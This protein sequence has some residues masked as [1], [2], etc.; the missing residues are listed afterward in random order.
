M[1]KLLNLIGDWNP[2]LFR[3]LKGRFTRRNMAIAIGASLAT[4]LL[5]VLSYLGS[6]PD[7]IESKYRYSR[8][9]TGNLDTYS[10]IRE[11][12]RS[13][14]VGDWFVNWQLWNFDLFMA[15]SIT[16]IGILL[17]I[18]SHLINADLTKEEHRGTLGFVRLSPQPAQKIILGKILGVP[19]LV[20]LGIALALPLHF[21]VGLQAHIAAPWIAM[22][23]FMAIAACFTCFSVAVLW[24]F[25]GQ[26]FFGGF[27]TWLY[28]GSLGFYLMIM[29]ILCFE[30]NLPSDSPFDWLRVV[31]P[32]NIFYYLVQQSSLQDQILNYFH[33]P[34]GLKLN[35]TARP[36]GRRDCSV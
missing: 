19:S 5:L 29:T 25:I 30:N 2:Q 17:I 12:L 18:G 16:G 15:L 26:E 27:Q 8:Y 33:H 21:F 14:P 1:T 34:I 20:Y 13:S 28:S 9:C 31:Y 3:E 35:F 22:V 11:C 10:P 6:L 7:P 32:G 36:I 23:D 24:S 4:Q